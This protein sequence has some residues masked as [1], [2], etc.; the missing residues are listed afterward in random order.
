MRPDFFDVHTHAQFAAYN[1]DREEVLARAREAH[2]WVVNVG[3]ERGTSEAAIALAKKEKEGVFATAG[4]HPTSAVATEKFDYEFYKK[5]GKDK[6]VVAIGECGL[7]Y[8]RLGDESKAEQK[9]VFLEHIRL[10]AELEKPLMIHCREAVPAGRQAFADLID[11]LRAH[12]REVPQGIVHFMSG[13]KADAEALLDMGLSFSFGGVVT[14]TSD[15][16][17]VVR[18]VPKT[19]LLLETDAPYVAPVPYRGKRNEPAYVIQTAKRIAE[20]QN[21]SISV[22]GEQ[23]T[24]NALAI[25]GLRK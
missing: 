24:S 2:V 18:Y 3:T 14:F 11:I 21:T 7:D 19:N 15:Y 16:D 12:Y 13:T 6:A 4:L 25:F 23:T 8:Y 22:L 5:L 9:Q 10:A 20:L 1:K 17:E